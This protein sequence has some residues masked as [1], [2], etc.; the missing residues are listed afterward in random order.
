VVF[1]IL[2]GLLAG[3]LLGCTRLLNN[4]YKRLGGIYGAGACLG[5][6]SISGAQSG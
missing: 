3:G 1:G 6:V 5:A 2:A 4:K